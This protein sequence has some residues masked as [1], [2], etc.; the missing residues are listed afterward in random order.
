MDIHEKILWQLAETLRSACSGSEAVS[1]LLP[2]IA[3]WGIQEKGLL[4]QHLHLEQQ[5][6]KEL[7][8]ILQALS[9]V[10]SHAPAAFID[11]GAYKVLDTARDLFPLMKKVVELGKQGLLNA[12]SADDIYYWAA[13]K[14]SPLGLAPSLA[15]LVI[16]LLDLAD[17]S[18]VYAPWEH[19]GQLAARA[20][21]H[22][23]EVL[24]ETPMPLLAAQVLTV[25]ALDHWQVFSG[26]P[27][28]AP[29]V[30]EN[31]RL[32]R[33]ASAIAVPPMGVRYDRDVVENDLFNRFT[34]K[35]VSGSVL[36]LQ[37]LIA[38][39]AGR[40][41]AV[42]PNSVLFSVGAERSFRQGLIERG[43]IEAVIALP[44]GLL[45][46]SAI[47][48][49]VLVL[50]T[51]KQS[52]QIR[53]VN[54]N[55]EQFCKSATRKRTELTHI[56]VLVKL[57]RG[58]ESSTCAIAVRPEQVRSNDFNLE[59]GRYVLDDAAQKLEQILANLPLMKLGEHVEIIRS[60]Q[61]S[62]S[63]SG[64]AVQEVQ[65]SDIPDF[66]A[67]VSA[68]KDSLFDLNSPKA[69]TYFLQAGDILLAIKGSVGKV[70][71]VPEAPPAGEGG[72][73][74]GQSFVVLRSMKNVSYE[75]K[76]LLV[77]LRS[78]IGQ[79]LLSRLVVGASMPT[80]QLASLKD[81]D[82]P[83][84]TQE[85]MNTA[86]EILEYEVQIQQKIQQLRSKQASLASALW[87]L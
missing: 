81:L 42:V 66:G 57:A 17:G 74:A 87:N 21:R 34:E 2:F 1:L 48:T 27:V 36:Q 30:L 23:Y 45:T 31:G 69:K 58:V 59:V 5:Y 8:Q 68:S 37:H 65:A 39:T 86:A 22:G 10:Q 84:I 53:F 43:A 35:T 3:W 79:A 56:E 28:Q 62:T 19:S 20:C 52:H 63:F 61:H 72:W 70:G 9:Q 47:P 13:D 55:S 60:R 40:I 73:V 32:K 16:A 38:Q 7:L 33:F 75:P 6:D 80:I 26:D 82:I 78:E 67:I 85:A 77:Y 15:D 54:A 50:N 11:E 71:I 18:S 44:S 4:P 12:F 46:G 76:A 49:S 64:V 25:A 24:V 14:N 29:R 41:V 51:T 83:S